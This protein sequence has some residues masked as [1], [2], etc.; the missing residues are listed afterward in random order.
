MN[1]PI[2]RA[3]QILGSQRKLAICCNVS[4]PAISKWLK[5]QR[6]SAEYVNSIVQATAGKVQAYE[7]RPD[8]FNIE[9]TNTI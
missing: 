5:G 6:V 1:E 2:A 3:I 7:L 4:Q 8:I 9:Q